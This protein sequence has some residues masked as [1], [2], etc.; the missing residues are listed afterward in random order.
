MDDVKET[1]SMTP[2]VT[3]SIQWK[4]LTD[5]VLNA[6][7]T[8]AIAISD[9]NSHDTTVE[10][11]FKAMQN[12]LSDFTRVLKIR[13]LMLLK[14]QYND[15][16]KVKDLLNRYLAAYHKSTDKPKSSCCPLGL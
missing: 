9:E 7:Q 1:D 16:R 8:W 15:V 5:Q 4:S 14:T 2:F 11:V 10:E 12:A 13:K 6:L 3:S